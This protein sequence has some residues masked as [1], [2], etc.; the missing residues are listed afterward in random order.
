VNDVVLAEMLR[1]AESFMPSLRT[2]M[3]NRIWTGFRPATPD[4]LPLIGAWPG[5]K[6]V[7]I[8]AGHEGL[9]IT[10]A[11]GTAAIIAAGITGARSPLDAAAFDPAR[12]MPERTA[13]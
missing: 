12:A 7:W 4:S 11:T 6:G 1:R 5:A 13:A 10:T 9:G 8:A 3:A 2:V